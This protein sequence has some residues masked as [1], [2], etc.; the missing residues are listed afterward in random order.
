VKID[1]LVASIRKGRTGTARAR[2]LAYLQE[3]PE[4]IFRI[5]RSDTIADA[6]AVPKRTVEHVLWSLH[7]DGEI[8]RARLGKETWYG[9]HAAIELL[10][11]GNP[12]ARMY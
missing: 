1:D 9:A 11:S 6:L 12:S 3:H 2:V 4:E 8:G 10:I 7:R 5:R